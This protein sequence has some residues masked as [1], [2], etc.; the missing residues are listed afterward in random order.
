MKRAKKKGLLLK[1]LVENKVTL[2]KGKLDMRN[3]RVTVRCINKKRLS[4]TKTKVGGPK[5][6]TVQ[7]I[8]EKE[9]YYEQRQS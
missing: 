4:W 1:V 6:V 8:S 2:N 3:Y 5:K 9:G 7:G